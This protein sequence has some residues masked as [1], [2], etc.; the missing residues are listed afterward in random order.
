M[1]IRNIIKARRFGLISWIIT[2]DPSSL[3]RLKGCELH[4]SPPDS[5][6]HPVNQ[7][8]GLGYRIIESG[9]AGL[10]RKCSET[11]L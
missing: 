10:R 9:K 5:P 7:Q 11:I 4:S 1:R 6:P 8:S 2:H 3:G